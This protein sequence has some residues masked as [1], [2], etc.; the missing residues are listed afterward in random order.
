M[1]QTPSRYADIARTA[2]VAYD[3]PTNST[4]TLLRGLNNAVFEV[5]ADADVRFALRV[6]RPGWR[7]ADQIASELAFQQAVGA[8][9]DG[10]RIDVPRPV[11]AS[12]GDLVVR[13]LADVGT[14]GLCS[15]LTW[16]DG[17]PLRPARG[18]GPRAA[19][20]LGEALARLHDA[21]ASFQPPAGFDLPR[22]DADGLFGAHSPYLSGA[23]VDELRDLLPAD[24]HALFRRVAD[25]TRGAFD[26]FEAAS[27]PGQFGVIHNDFIL[28]NC[29]FRLDRRSWRVGVLDFDDC[30]W[31]WFCSD[32]GAV[33]GNLADFRTSFT[34]LSRAFLAGYR[35]IRPLPQGFDQH[36][37]LM[38]ATRHAA[39]CLWALGRGRTTGD[40]DAARRQL[41]VR[42]QLVRYCLAFER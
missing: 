8:R 37:P 20:L 27:A 18:L 40:M 22:W 14:P 11:P 19:E 33:L 24:D 15:L 7:T 39:N 2:L 16:L 26:E 9:L 1:R 34:R 32:L 10:S 3:L 38:M 29:H 35:T 6:H 30:G 4:A 28:G 36:W 12:S 23:D 21:G 13:V 42:M 25:R 31:G 5:A 17:V 41:D